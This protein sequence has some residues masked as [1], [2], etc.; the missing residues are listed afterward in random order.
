MSV[1]HHAAT[2]IYPIDAW[3]R[4]YLPGGSR[5]GSP[6]LSR[7]ILV[8]AAHTDDEALGCGGTIAR[9]V[10]EGDTVN[11]V[12]LTDGLS[13]RPDQSGTDLDDRVRAAREAHAILGIS[14]V[15]YLD[16][17]DNQM[18]GVV[19]LEVVRALE[20]I[21]SAFE[22][23]VIYT[24]R[25]GDRNVD[26]R[27]TH[28][29]VMT[30]CRPM[31]DHHV[32]EV[33]TFEIMSSTDWASPTSSQFLPVLYI[34][35]SG[36]IDLKLRALAAYG[37]ELRDEPHSRSLSHLEHLARHRGHTVGLHA[38]EAFMVMRALH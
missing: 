28:E 34:D 32:R 6:S 35:I 4:S 5:A 21:L 27:V 11:A 2:E 25:S 33:Y 22:P 8:V 18:D 9:H 30:A 3:A 17:P 12:F 10:A 1:C 24:H 19:L 29:A 13:S 36:Y 16:F 23:E 37:L 15:N 14:E 20:R 38:A 31:P 7:R 26:H